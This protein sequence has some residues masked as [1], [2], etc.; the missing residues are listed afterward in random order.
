MSDVSDAKSFSAN[1]QKWIKE[2][3]MLRVRLVT[4]KATEKE[5]QAYEKIR[6]EVPKIKQMFG[7]GIVGQPIPA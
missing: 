6:D 3:L 1:A 5:R 4:G 2:L 7:T